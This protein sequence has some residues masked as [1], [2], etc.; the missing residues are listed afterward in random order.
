MFHEWIAFGIFI[1]FS[2]VGFILSFLGI[3]GT[4]VVLLGAL[5]YNLISWSFAIPWSTIA[6]LLGLAVLGEALEWIITAYGIK[7]K[8]SKYAVIGSIAGAIIG[9]AVLSFIPL[10]GTI[11]GLI[12]GAMLGAFIAEYIHKNNTKKAWTAAKAALKG[13]ALV[14]LTKTLI[15]IVQV[16]I[17]IRII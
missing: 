5:L 1:I 6:I 9:A 8:A 3:G 17:I 7:K 16:F 13:R 4:F 15:T 11:I 14:S 10:I 12:L 2:I